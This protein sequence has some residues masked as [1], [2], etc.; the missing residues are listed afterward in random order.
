[1]IVSVSFFS[2]FYGVG[3]VVSLP[4]GAFSTTSVSSPLPAD[5]LVPSFPASSTRSASTTRSFFPHVFET[6]SFSGLSTSSPPSN[7]SSLSPTSTLFS[8]TSPSPTL[9]PPDPQTV[10]DMHTVLQRRLDF[11][12]ASVTQVSQIASWQVN[13]LMLLL[14]HTLSPDPCLPGYK[15]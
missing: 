1:M 7:S 11:I 13:Y 9:S 2:L 3:F 4:R 14:R 12:I 10:Q 8:S 6:T 15:H 5:T